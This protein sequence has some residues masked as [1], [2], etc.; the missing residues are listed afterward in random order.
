MHKLFKQSSK[1][2]STTSSTASF[3][4]ASSAASIISNGHNHSPTSKAGIYLVGA[5]YLDTIMHVNTFPTEDTKHRAQRVEQRRG[6]NA[7]NSAEILGQDPRA[8]VW[9]MSSMPSQIA[10]K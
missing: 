8:K 4:G 1:A 3:S 2:S 6:G 9:Y 7:A 5:T 10:S